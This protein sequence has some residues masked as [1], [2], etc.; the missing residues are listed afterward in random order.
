MS[1]AERGILYETY[2]ACRPGFNGGVHKQAAFAWARR[3]VSGASVWPLWL[4]RLDAV[5]W[6]VVYLASFLAMLVL[7]TPVL[8]PVA[9][10]ATLLVALRV[11]HPASHALPAL[12]GWGTPV[13][14]AAGLWF[15][16]WVRQHC[17]SHH[18]HT[19]HATL[20]VDIFDPHPVLRFTKHL[21]WRHH[22]W[23][24]PLYAL[25]LYSLL[26]VSR[27]AVSDFL[28]V[29]GDEMPAMVAC[30]AAFAAVVVVFP[31]W[32]HGPGVLWLLA[33]YYLATGLVL[34]LLFAVSHVHVGADFQSSDPPDL[35]M[36]AWSRR[37]V[38][39]AVDWS[40][41]SRAACYLTGGL[42]L[43][44][45]HHLF[46]AMHSADLFARARGALDAE[47]QVRAVPHFG[48]ALLGH[49]THLFA[50]SWRA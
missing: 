15:R 11:I 25:P 20:D 17:L 46:P 39:F 44:A 41:S 32:L 6:V 50:C 22:A 26:F 5:A 36:D 42:N 23:L 28:L 27:V 14:A 38:A 48:G 19:N 4:Q 21:P 30:K 40:R 1:S 45:E 31:T 34:A 2:H 7:H 35:G 43:Q 10:L 37:Q 33:A 12:Q 47:F 3:A 16:N 24:Q 49:L 13:Y 9:V 18:L 29:T 8:L